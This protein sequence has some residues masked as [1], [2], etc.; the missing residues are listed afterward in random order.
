M[1]TISDQLKSITDR[2]NHYEQF[3]KLSK[4]RA[5]MLWYAVEALDLDQDSAHEAVSY[6]G[7]NDKS[8]DL[9]HIDD[10]FERVI[11][12]QGK[13]SVKGN[14]NPTVGE[15]FELL[16]T[17][18]WLRN[19]EMLR[20]EGRAD[21][22]AAA[23]EY[24]EA[25]SK[26]YSI[27][28]IFVYLGPPKREIQDAAA[29]FTSSEAGNVPARSARV[30]HL[31]LLQQIHDEYINKATR[32]GSETLSVQKFFEQSGAY[33]KALVASISGE[34][35]RRLYEVHNDTLFDRNI[36]L[37]LGARKGSV[38]AVIRETLASPSERQNFWAYNNGL[39]FICDRY[40]VDEDTG[41]LTLHNFS[42]VNGCQT[43]V[44]VANS[45]NDA[46][47]EVTLLA[48]FIAA[49][50]EPVVDS[51]IRYTN[52]QTP[53]RPW[54]I[55]SQDKVQKRLQ[56]D[57]ARDPHPFFYALRPG[58]VRN[59]SQ[60]D[61]KR[62][63][64]NGKLQVIQYDLL[65]QYLAAFNGLPSVAYKDKG[66][67]FT[68]FRETVFA[69]DLRVE[70]A[71]LSWLGGEV[72]EEAVR[73]AIKEAAARDEKD[74]VRILKRG[75]KMFVLA[76]MAI[77]LA[78]RNGTA[79][80]ARLKRDVA[81]SNKTRER[82]LQYAKLA[83][84]WYVQVV[85]DL[86]ETGADLSQLVRTQESFPRIRDKVLAYWKVQSMSKAWVEDALPRL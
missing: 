69:T 22:A 61:R 59:L 58:E 54:D 19:P 50:R 5:F 14:Y 79:Y 28:Y 44:S 77:I 70:Q 8:I 80:L 76:V 46:S 52:S 41:N 65:A 23:V 29:I 11:I 4:G 20:R 81:G 3:Y 12:A 86:L 2:V 64:R 72:A 10:E 34:E 27:E 84:I 9:F 78:E 48:R 83:V 39:T 45:K 47:R 35:L 63:T 71:M 1:V 57:F 49:S 43:T 42:I 55:G 67:V 18:D 66:K 36:R 68:T 17:S 33:G 15:F 25:I 53:I 37:F 7:G 62:F 75:G 40:D 31:D 85:K 32:I 60:A 51:I 74:E 73:E 21:L 26:G 82:L 56:K 24:N 16:H 6:D 30:L 38:N 13:Y